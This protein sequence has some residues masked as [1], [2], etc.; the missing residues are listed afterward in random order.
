MTSTS[1]P[2]ILRCLIWYD[3]LTVWLVCLSVRLCCYV[4]KDSV[5]HSGTNYLLVNNKLDHATR[6]EYEVYFKVYDPEMPDMV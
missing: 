1:R 2:M 6:D 5:I 3:A 4:C